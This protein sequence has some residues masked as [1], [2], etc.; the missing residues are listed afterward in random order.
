MNDDELM[1][2]VRDAFEVLDPVRRTCWR[3]P[4]RSIIWRTRAA[5]L[6]EL[7]HDRVARTAAGVRG[8]AG[9]TLT[10]TCPGRAVEIEVA[11]RGRHREITG[12]LVPSSAAVV[13]VRHR[14]LPPDGITARASKPGCSA[15]R[16]CRR[17]WSAWCSGWRTAPR[18]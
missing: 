13:Q 9:R 4:A 7:A 1:S 14:D 11:E 18:S 2:G 8:V 3:R 15:S 5:T 6:A 12:R 16:A 17:G 10:F